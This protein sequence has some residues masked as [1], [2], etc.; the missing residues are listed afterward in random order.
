[1]LSSTATLPTVLQLPPTGRAPPRPSGADELL[2]LRVDVDGREPLHRSLLAVRSGGAACAHLDERHAADGTV[3]R[4]VGDDGRVHGAG[5]LVLGLGFSAPWS[6]PPPPRWEQ[7]GGR[8][9]GGDA[10]DEDG[11]Q[12]ARA[13]AAAGS[14]ADGSG[15]SRGDLRHRHIPEGI[16]PRPP[17][18]APAPRRSFHRPGS[19]RPW[20]PRP[21]WSRPP[22]APHAH[23]SQ[24]HLAV[25][26]PMR[27]AS[28][29]ASR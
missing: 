16:P 17:P 26:H 28:A 10:C 18:A 12:R 23:G 20:P 11:D 8:S 21:G 13:E 29:R 6:W 3:A 19:R 4:V 9:T 5:V 27:C 2:P 22:A 25:G 24:A 15:R 7:P 1:M 14:V